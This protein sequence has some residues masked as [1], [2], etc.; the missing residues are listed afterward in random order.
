MPY[1]RVCRT[2]LGISDLYE[3]L[4]LSVTVRSVPYPSP[5]SIA[6]VVVIAATAQTSLVPFLLLFFC[7]GSML[8]ATTAHANLAVMLAAPK[9]LR[10][11][12]LAVNSI[13]LHALG[14]VPSPTL[15]GA[16]KDTLAPHCAEGAGALGKQQIVVDGP[17]FLVDAVG[18]M[19][20]LGS[21]EHGVGGG[22]FDA[23]WVGSWTGEGAGE[24]WG[25]N[26]AYGLGGISDACR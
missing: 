20:V 23:A 14:D 5:L 25:T 3:R 8:F 1:H 7:G 26:G 17:G 16:L 2:F 12:S 24:G 13:A 10:P 9:H 6:I 4:L 21:G 11:L 22:E 18:A 19:G 15:I